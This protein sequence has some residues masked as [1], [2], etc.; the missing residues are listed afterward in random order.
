M[1][2]PRAG[3]GS[4]SRQQYVLDIARPEAHEHLLT[5]IDALVREHSIDYLKWDRNRDLFEAVSREA[6]GDR[7]SV[8]PG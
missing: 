1:L 8:R 5:H 2:G 7:P 3:L 4:N 6:G